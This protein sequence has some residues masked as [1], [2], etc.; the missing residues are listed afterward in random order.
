[1][2]TTGLLIMYTQWGVTSVMQIPINIIP[3]CDAQQS[4]EKIGS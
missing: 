2:P 1:M 4:T 3:M